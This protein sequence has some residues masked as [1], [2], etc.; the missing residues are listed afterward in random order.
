MTQK[1][2]R[3]YKRYSKR[4]SFREKRRRKIKLFVGM[5]SFLLV[6]IF[7][8]GKTIHTSVSQQTF[9]VS[10]TKKDTNQTK[11]NAETKSPSI[12]NQTSDILLVN[13]NNPLPEDYQVDLLTLPDGRHL[14]AREA[15]TPLCDMLEAGRKEGLHFL[16]CSSYRDT[17]YQKQL[18]EE[19]VNKL[20]QR[21][22]SYKE[23]YNEVSK[24]TMPPGCSEHSTGLAFDIVS[25]S[26]QMLNA[27]Q[28]NTAENQWLQQHCAEYGFILRYPKGKE[29]MTKINYESW[30]FRYV[31]KKH[32]AYIMEHGITLEEYVTMQN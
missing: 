23:A 31:G 5:S 12:H 1:K 3:V 25:S 26:Y 29:D 24:E 20:M 9:Q 2:K 16:I 21:G 13:K 17:R 27:G 14:S 18:F 4:K 15:Y 30:H 11:E 6:L 7:L 32:A 19:D 22:Y 10:E 8:F 28:E